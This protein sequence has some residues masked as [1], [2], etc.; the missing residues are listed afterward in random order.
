MA[1]N[2][3]GISRRSFVAKSAA[4]VAGFTIVPRHCLARSGQVSPNERVRIAAIG[5]AGQG[6]SDIEHLNATGEA[7]FVGL[8]DVDWSKRTGKTFEQ[9][10]DAKRFHDFRK[11]FDEM[12]D[13]F[14]AVLVATPDH[15]HAVA[16]MTA[17]KHGKHIYCEKPLSHSV[18]EVRQLMAAAKEKG[19]VSQLGNQ[20]HSYNSIRTFCEWIWDGAIGDVH[21]VHVACG[22]ENSGL[23]QLEAAKMAQPAPASL[24]WEL[25]LGPAKSRAYNNAYCPTRWRGWV[26]FG[27][28]TLGDWT[29]HV[30]D[31]VFWALDLGAPHTVQAEV[32]NYDPIKDADVY[33]KGAVVRFEF[34]G[35]GERGPVTLYWHAGTEGIPHP[36]G[37]DPKLKLPTTG[38]VV[39]GDKGTIMH[40]SHGALQCR[41]VPES[42]MI[43]YDEKLK[44]E[45]LKKTLP[46]LKGGDVETWQNSLAHHYDWLE[47][48]KAGRKAGSDFS[49]GGP[50]SEI[51]LTGDIAIRLAGTELKWD[52]PA[53]RFT[54]SP[55]ATAMLTPHFENGWTL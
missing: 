35:K 30:C 27:T 51:A 8:C 47:A 2:R 13:Q 7:Q 11:M 14:D 32:K 40:G 54:N 45:P 15:T 22:V 10:P 4:A 33:P 9:F 52:S 19:V 41:I 24:D 3:K 49:Y 36:P 55:E 12:A 16:A 37:L 1:R 23:D 25:W 20:G 43:E 18:W 17:I 5:I 21:T 28:G 50:L 26:P 34:A 44:R 53:M 39:I 29:C 6:G 31:P 46:R 38:G 42:K 48:I